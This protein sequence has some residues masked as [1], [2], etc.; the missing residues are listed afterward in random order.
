MS[1][2]AATVAAMELR[3]ICEVCDREAV[4]TPEDAYQAGSANW[5]RPM[6]K[7]L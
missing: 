3:H 2:P 6:P 1:P 5:N 4:L 7:A